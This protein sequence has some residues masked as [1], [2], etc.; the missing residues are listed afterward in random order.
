M[1]IKQFKP[2]TP[3]RRTMTIDRKEDITAERPEKS[4]TKKIKKS[5]GRNNKGR[6][7]S[8]HRGGGH[9]RL[10]RIIDFKRDKKDVPAKV[11]TIEYDPNRGARIALLH[12][13]D[14]EKR[15]II[16]PLGLKTGDVVVSGEQVEIATGNSMPLRSIPI[17]TIV[18]NIELNPGR[19]GAI[20][21]GAGSFAQITGREGGKAALKLPSGELRTVTDTCRAVIGQVGNPDHENIVVGKAGKKRWQG[22]KPRNRAVAMNPV[23]HPMGGGEGRSKSGEHPVSPGGTKAKGFRTR[24]KNKKSNNFIIRRRKSKG[25]SGK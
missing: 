7:T 9:K 20:A 10:Y 3:A 5:S 14:G 16:A 4:L 15:Y 23:D 17:G 13:R 24:K 22:R 21:R 2:A 1:G 12:Y 8:R 18:H 25:G 6:N 11:A 19:G